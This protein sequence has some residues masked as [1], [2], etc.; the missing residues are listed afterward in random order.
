MPRSVAKRKGAYYQIISAIDENLVLD[1]QGGKAEKELVCQVSKNSNAGST[2]FHFIDC[3]PEIE[4]S[5]EV[6]KSGIYFIQSQSNSNYMLDIKG[7]SKENKAN[8][9]LY[10]KNETVAQAFEFKYE[11]GYYT[12]KNLGSGKML[13]VSG[14]GYMPGTNVWQYASNGS[15]AQKWKASVNEDGSYTFISVH[16]GMALD[17]SG[18]KI[19]SGSNIQVYVPN[20]SQAQRFRLEKA[21]SLKNRYHGQVLLYSCE[22]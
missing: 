16:N 15:K 21:L 8:V 9:Q 6:I 20:N 5:Q 12:I 1:V 4:S 2:L 22:K 18:G 17:I 7:G 11:K 14:G 19:L 13:D 10:K 3:V